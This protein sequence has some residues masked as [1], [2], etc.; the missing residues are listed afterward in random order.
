MES[1]LTI[2]D[3]LRIIKRRKY[4]I[5]AIT[6]SFVVVTYFFLPRS[7]AVYEA[8][9]LV[10]VFL[11]SS[12][13]EPL[14]SDFFFDD[15]DNIA[16]QSTIISSQRIV[17]LTLKRIEL[18]DPKVEYTDF[19]AYPEYFE[20][21]DK[22]QQRIDAKPV[23]LKRSGMMT[24]IIEV[25]AG[26]D[27]PS[28][29]ITFVNTLVDVY[30]EESKK[31]QNKEA[32]ET[33][34]FIEK[35][36]ENFTA[37]LAESESKLLNFIKNTLPG[38]ELKHG[39]VIE[40]QIGYGLIKEK[41]GH[42]STL[43][44]KLNER[45]LGNNN[46]E[47]WKVLATKSGGYDSD[48]FANLGKLET[49]KSKLQEFH[50][51]SSS[52]VQDLEEK[53]RTAID[54]V[55]V[56]INRELSQLRA[57]ENATLDL[58]ENN[59][60][61]DQLKRAVAMNEGLVE[62]LS[63]SYQD[64]LIQTSK[65]VETVK[66]L[67][68]ATSAK[69][70]VGATQTS[71][72]LFISIF[73]FGIGSTIAAF[74]EIYNTSIVVVE[75]VEKHVKLSV[76]GVIPHIEDF[77]DDVRLTSSSSGKSN[78]NS[79][80]NKANGLI[81]HFSPKSIAAESYR[82]F[83]T[84]LDFA[85]AASGGKIILFTS[86]V[87]GEGKSTTIT[88]TAMTIAQM[89]NRVLLIDCNLRRPSIYRAFGIERKPGLTDIVHGTMKWRDAVKGITDMFLGDVLDISEALLSPG[90]DNLDI[91]TSG[92]LPTNPAEFLSLKRYKEFLAEVK[93]SYDVILID[94]PPLLHV[95]DSAIIAPNCDH[96]VLVYQIGRVSRAS[97]IRTKSTLEHIKANILG[98]VLN[99]TKAEL[100][101]S[102]YGTEYA[103]PYYGESAEKQ[104]AAKSKLPVLGRLFSNINIK[105]TIRKSKSEV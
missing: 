74:L 50:L 83:R 99:D 70:V 62:H 79:S 82:A 91:I 61:Y 30:R 89:G 49:E 33:K 31:E 104:V 10:E 105:S 14:L 13:S 55:I 97:L 72:L 96:V 56:N 15:S 25:T 12:A 47:D 35:Q 28:L 60:E 85:R 11:N 59:I 24:D 103:R 66:M 16:T 69:A 100:D 58:L 48:L 6:V 27:N 94:S 63:T 93:Q 39:D 17:F 21:V 44:A 18:I 98:V 41:I 87:L 52:Q 64:A 3:I 90:L 38:V 29:A 86:S 37:K 46:Y 4:L 9:A 5:I 2:P 22:F 88:N 75:D 57:Q 84:N 81:V 45:K 67:E 76:L 40:L 73:G 26:A 78:G 92:S 53:I 71:M 36:L 101:K 1:E 32:H 7:K 68:F 51:E 102:S 42:Y 23:E 43:K 95:T 19:S 54:A 80:S 65:D 77:K 34:E 8:T 20:L